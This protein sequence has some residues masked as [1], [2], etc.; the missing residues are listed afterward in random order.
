MTNLAW[1]TIIPMTCAGIGFLGGINPISGADDFT[2]LHTGGTDVMVMRG[3]NS[4]MEISVG[5]WGPNWGWQGW[6]G[7]AVPG[8][9]SMALNCS[10]KGF[11]ANLVYRPASK[12]F[13]VDASLTPE[14]SSEITMIMIG[15]SFPGIR[16]GSWKAV[17]GSGE[18]MSGELPLPRNVFGEF[19]KISNIEIA[20]E[21]GATTKLGLSPAISVPVDGG[22]LRLEFASGKVEAGKNYSFKLAVELPGG[23]TLYSDPTKAPGTRDFDKWY[24][25]AGTGH[26]SG[27]SLL[28]MSDWSKEPAGAK[29]RIVIEDEKLLYG[30]KPIKLWGLNVCYGDCAPKKDLADKRAALYKRYGINSVRLHKYADGA[31][32]QGILKKDDASEFDPEALDRMDYFVSKLKESGIFVKL[33]PIFY[34]KP[35]QANRKDIPYFDEFKENDGVAQTGGGA[36]YLGLELQDLQMRQMANLLKH[37]NP[38][39]SM[40]YAQD[41][42]IAVIEITNEDSILFYGTLGVLQKVPSLRKRAGEAFAAWLKRKYKTK[43]KLLAAWSED[44]LGNFKAEGF[45]DES[46]EDN[47]IY[48]IGNPWFYSPDQLDGSQKNRKARLL[49]TVG[50]LAELQDETY[51]RMS[52]SIR[53]AGYDGALLASNWQAGEGTSHYM[54]LHSDAQIG[55]VDRHNYFG[56]GSPQIINNT[57][58]LALPGSGTLSSSFQQVKGRPF[59]LSEWIHVMPNE[60]GVEGPAIIGAYGMGLQ[61]WDVSYMFQNRDPGEFMRALQTSRNNTWNVAAPNILGSFPAVSRMVRRGDVREAKNTHTLNV[62]LPSVLKGEWSFQD[63]TRQEH[64]VKSFSTGVV[65]TEALAVARVAVAFVDQPTQTHPFNLDDFRKDGGYASDTGE[66]FWSPGVKPMDGYFTVETE[67]T[68]AIVGFA[69]DRTLSANFAEIT[70][71]S[72]FASIFLTAKNTDKNLSDDKQIIVSAIARCRNSG[73]NYLMDKIISDFGD[74]KKGPILMEPVRAEIRL[75]RKGGAQVHI[76]DHDGM[77]TGTTIPLENGS[78]KIDT[79]RDKTPYYLIE[80]H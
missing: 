48:P 5:G 35:R 51:R 50:F 9:D 29:G 77:R 2:A 71:R 54:N 6:K 34:V 60:W 58:M 36:M 31:G 7:D 74:E 1:R 24:Q 62:H 61:G 59:M 33:S 55:I 56:G 10:T 41:P 72:R 68:E 64:D 40:T 66:L 65:P 70:P 79:A 17:N 37:K 46:W 45:P 80:Y 3:E 69:E 76:L 38:Y 20:G 12:G 53:K 26:P 14:Q 25:F 32:W 8:S 16:K 75:L 67:G 11:R 27:E 42:A 52:D 13:S 47:R 73:A 63:K 18:T 4:F 23:C 43:D 28:D 57:S 44:M 19:G 22:Q 15:C 21:D 49:D 39:T 78:F 30:G